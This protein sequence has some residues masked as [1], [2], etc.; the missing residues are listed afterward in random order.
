LTARIYGPPSDHRRHCCVHQAD[1]N[2]PPFV[3]RRR[4]RVGARRSRVAALDAAA[5]H[6]TDAAL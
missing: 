4:A 5:R 1:R 2:L 6:R 3:G